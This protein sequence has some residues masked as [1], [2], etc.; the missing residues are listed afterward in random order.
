VPTHHPHNAS[1][2][3]DNGSL[4]VGRDNSIQWI[5]V[6][7]AAVFLAVGIGSVAAGHW[8]AGVVHATMGVTGWLSSRS[9]CESRTY[10]FRG[11]LVYML[12]T[13][14]GVVSMHVSMQAIAAVTM[15][16]GG[17]IGG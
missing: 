11:G 2:P 13:L 14:T 10:L 4:L 12:L 3:R 17:V 7:V 1:H 15:V 8:A 5:T 6:A 16:V 9:V